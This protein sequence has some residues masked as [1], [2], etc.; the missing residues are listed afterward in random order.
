MADIISRSFKMGKIFAASNDI[1][2]YFNTRFLL[3]QNESWH[4]CQVTINLLSCVTACLRGKLLPMASLLR[5]TRIGRNTGSI[6][7]YML[8]HRKSTPSLIPLYPLLS[9]TF[10]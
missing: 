6:G 10:S 7:K 9:V 4:K 2:A 1:I 3:M 5:Q 8:P